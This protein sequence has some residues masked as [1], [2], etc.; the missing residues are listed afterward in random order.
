MAE[1][2]TYNQRIYVNAN[3][4]FKNKSRCSQGN[5]TALDYRGRDF[6]SITQRAKN[7]AAHL[8]AYRN[9]TSLLRQIVYYMRAWSIYALHRRAIRARNAVAIALRVHGCAI[10]D[11]GFYRLVQR[12]NNDDRVFCDLWRIKRML[13]KRRDGIFV[14]NERSSARATIIFNS[15]AFCVYVCESGLNWIKL[16]FKPI[17]GLSYY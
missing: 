15:S 12:V 11:R 16:L 5:V 13:H 2:L 1:Y 9:L 14:C 17:L 8:F 6:S 7:R 10:V 4:T 3:I